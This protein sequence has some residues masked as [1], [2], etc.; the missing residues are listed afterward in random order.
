M[1]AKHGFWDCEIEEYFVIIRN[2]DIAIS[3]KSKINVMVDRIF[4]RTVKTMLINAT[5]NKEKTG[6]CFGSCFR[7]KESEMG[8]RR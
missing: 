3:G 1:D 6:R 4:E 2:V 5:E 7:S 8:K